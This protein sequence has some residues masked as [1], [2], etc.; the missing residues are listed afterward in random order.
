MK[1]SLLVLTLAAVV[2]TPLRSA[3]AKPVLPHAMLVDDAAAPDE[4]AAKIL[5]AVD[6][7][8]TAFEDQSYTAT[9]EVFKGE[10][11]S[12]TVT[13]AAQM[14]G[15]NQLLTFKTALKGMKV[16][17]LPKGDLYVYLPEFKK[18]RRVAAHMKKQGFLGSEF[19]YQDMTDVRLSRSYTAK[20]AGREGKITTLSLAPK[21]GLDIHPMQ[22]DIDASKGGVTTL[23]Y[24]NSEG[25]LVRKQT[26]TDWKEI[27]G[28]LMPTKV[29]MH[30]LKTGDTT[31]ITLSSV[32]V[33]SGLDASI[34]SRRNLLRG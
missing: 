8:N 11:L 29:S 30:N 33:N 18:A 7:R 14:K 17:M 1:R 22:I 25:E 15:L 20:L 5:T 23:R 26:R 34:F 21:E 24:Y 27:E 6:A 10:K 13:F 9:M 28:E 4:L 12:K 16:L 19:T 3:A 2:L 32:V 31:V